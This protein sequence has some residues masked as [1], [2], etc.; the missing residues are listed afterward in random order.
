MRN[1]SDQQILETL[2]LEKYFPEIVWFTEARGTESISIQLKE[3]ASLKDGL[4]AVRSV[5]P[6][7]SLENYATSNTGFYIWSLGEVVG[8]LHTKEEEAPLSQ[9]ATEEIDLLNGSTTT[10]NLEDLRREG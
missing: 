1:L 3:D 9:E 4:Y 6:D 2:R 5:F 7:A 8:T 10:W